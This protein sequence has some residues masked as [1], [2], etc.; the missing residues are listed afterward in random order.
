MYRSSTQHCKF[1]SNTLSSTLLRPLSSPGTELICS[2]DRRCRSSLAGLRE[3]PFL[4]FSNISRGTIAGVAVTRGHSAF[5]CIASG[6][7]PMRM[8]AR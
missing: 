7:G 5:A 6:F 4:L 3:L 8:R 2:C 1:T